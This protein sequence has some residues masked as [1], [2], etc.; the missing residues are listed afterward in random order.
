MK[1]GVPRRGTPFLFGAIRVGALAEYGV[2][3]LSLNYERA[4]FKV[5]QFTTLATVG[6]PT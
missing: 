2:I 5:E 4:R 6:H 1:K 3:G